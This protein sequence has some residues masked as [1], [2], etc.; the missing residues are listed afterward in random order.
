MDVHDVPAD[1][2]ADVCVNRLGRYPPAFLVAAVTFE[3]WCFRAGCFKRSHSSVCLGLQL[4]TGQRRALNWA[5]LN[6]WLNFHIKREYYAFANG[7]L[8]YCA[9]AS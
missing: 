3:Q 2:P 6:L 9:A 1:V 5:D 8:T 7:F 4:N